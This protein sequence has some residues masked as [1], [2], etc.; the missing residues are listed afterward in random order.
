MIDRCV[1]HANQHLIGLQGL[2]IRKVDQFYHFG[3]F[4]K[5][6]ELKCIHHLSAFF[7]LCA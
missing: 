6:R 3:W 5:S 2:W 4:A 7:L 1:F